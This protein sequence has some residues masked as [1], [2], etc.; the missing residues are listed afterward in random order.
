[1]NA[2]AR[3]PGGWRRRSR[4]SWERRAAGWNRWRDAGK[5]AS[6]KTA[7]VS[8]MV[9]HYAEDK[10]FIYGLDIKNLDAMRDRRS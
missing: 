6:R 1:M 10:D 8:A 9:R 2:G 4:V 7:F 5:I 3:V